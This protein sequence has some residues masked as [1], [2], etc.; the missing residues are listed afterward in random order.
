M[1][2]RKN[3]SFRKAA[4]GSRLVASY[5]NA[6]VPDAII[7]PI[8]PATTAVIIRKTRRHDASI[9]LHWNNP[10]KKY[11]PIVTRQ[12]VGS[13]LTS[14]EIPFHKQSKHVKQLSI[15]SGPGIKEKYI[16]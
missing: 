12:W 3:S 8:P 4:V 14:N 9:N 15:L 16:D 7:F 13:F 2:S 11:R 1:I 10:S 5:F 6:A